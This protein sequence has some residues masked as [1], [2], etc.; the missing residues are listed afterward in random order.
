[1]KRFLLIPA[2]LVALLILAHGVA[3]TSAAASTPPP[4][5]TFT[6]TLTADSLISVGVPADIASSV[7]GNWS[8]NFAPDFTYTASFGGVVQSSGTFSADD[9]T[10]TFTD[11]GGA[12]SCQAQGAPVGSYNY[13]WG[14]TTLSFLLASDDCIGRVIVLSGTTYTFTG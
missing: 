2:L 5:G 13:F 4:F 1:M 6:G 14:G 10:V 12:Q 3:R 9:A 8:L 7:A 11:T